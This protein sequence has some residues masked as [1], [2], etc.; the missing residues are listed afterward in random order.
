MTVRLEKDC[1]VWQDK[2]IAFPLCK[3]VYWGTETLS[4]NESG[5]RRGWHGRIG[6]AIS[7][8]IA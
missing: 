2:L 6:S 5:D 8:G 7:R 1:F 3:K 4:N